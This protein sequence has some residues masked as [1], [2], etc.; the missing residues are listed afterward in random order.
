MK[1]TPINFCTEAFPESLRPLLAGARLFDGS[2]STK[3][4]V[5]FIDK[6]A[7]FYLKKAPGGTLS[8][9]AA[10]TR[11]FAEKGLA[12]QVLAYET[13][14]SDWLL[15]ERMPGEDCIDERYL[16]DPIRLCDTLAQILRALH[17]TDPTGCPVADHTA[18]YLTR[19]AENRRQGRWDPSY[20][21]M[22]TTP[23]EAW[24]LVLRIGPMLRSDTLLHGDYCLPNIMLDNW[25]FRGFIDLD[26]AGIG[27]RHV[28]LYWATWSLNYNLKTNQYRD[29]FLDAYGREHVSE[30]LLQ[31]V[32]A[33]EAFG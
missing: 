13:G 31:T 33:I 18:L 2:S 17:D 1:R 12:P 15:T 24:N 3:A 30:E 16:A 21:P 9:E 23:E 7:G 5:Y 20:A 4:R 27:D 22:G 26:H 11:W 8:R 29:R 6:G 10:T 19:A 28:D 14:D 32:A 25:Q